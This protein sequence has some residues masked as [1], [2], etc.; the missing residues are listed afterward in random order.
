[1]K[2][3]IKGLLA[4]IS[5]APAGQV[6]R[7]TAQMRQ[8]AE[9]AKHLENRLT[10]MRADLQHWRHRYEEKSNA[11]SEWKSTVAIGE[12]N[13]ERVKAKVVRA[14]AHAEEW[15]AKAGVL[16]AQ[17]QEL[18]TRLGNANRATTTSREHL[19]A[20]EVKLDL[21]ETAITVLDART[22]EAAVSRPAAAPAGR[23]PAT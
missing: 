10:G 3:A 20:M 1:M 4:T 8:A 16:A 5:L 18:R 22:R 15:K 17:V 12:A 11:V 14:E 9:K 21:I 7:A 13:L 2:A 23:D 19:M 6:E